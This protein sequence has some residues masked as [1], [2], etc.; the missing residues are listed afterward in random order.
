MFAK[1]SSSRFKTLF[2]LKWALLFIPGLNS[3]H[4][5]EHQLVFPQAFIGLEGGYQVAVDK[6][7]PG[8]DPTGGI[9]GVFGGV[10]L[11]PS[12][13]WDLGYQHHD[14]LQAPLTNV[15]IATRLIDSGLR[16]DWHW[17]RNVSLYG[18]LGIAYW[19]M[20]KTTPS[21]MD[22]KASSVSPLAETGVSYQLSPQLQLSAGYQYVDAIG[23]SHS[24]K[25]DSHAALL[26][27]SYTFGRTAPTKAAMPSHRQPV[28]DSSPQLATVHSEVTYRAQ[29]ATDSAHFN[30]QNSSQLS[31]IIDILRLYP[32]ARVEIVGHADAT[33]TRTYNLKL[34]RQR[35]QAV[36]DT[37]LRA[38]VRS[39]QVRIRSQGESTPI[40]SNKTAA[41]RAQN[42]RVDLTVLAFEYQ[43]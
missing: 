8:S 36:A 27:L 14:D 15:T 6:R 43:K 28:P 2:Y 41:G 9:I 1:T 4:A 38:G 5:S 12:W 19:E 21:E 25:Y 20:D 16:Y 18:R 22:I 39:E 23:Q 35:A 3:A 31:G 24:G 17:T 13:S 30:D 40:A 37:L 7:Y 10:R 11:S 32:Q 33:G 42:R 29:F 26:G 34:S